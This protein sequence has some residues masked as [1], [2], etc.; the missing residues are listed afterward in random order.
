MVKEKG[1]IHKGEK[2]VNVEYE[3]S[4]DNVFIYDL[5]GKELDF[6]SLSDL[7]LYVYGRKMKYEYWYGGVI[8]LANEHGKILMNSL[9]AKLPEKNWD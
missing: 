6:I 1:K 2:L 3:I 4:G 8:Y 7:L 9:L 5:K